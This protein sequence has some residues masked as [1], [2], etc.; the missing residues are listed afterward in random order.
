MQRSMLIFE[1]SIN[2][3]ST[4]RVYIYQLNRFL[5]F[6]DIKDYDELANTEQSKIQIMMEDYVMYLKK[7]VSPN[8][9]NGPISAIRAF[10]DCNDIELRW[11]KI[12][13]LTPAKVKKSG[14]EAW[15]TE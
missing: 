14:V 12:K 11:S 4:K 8:T 6:F 7:K 9:I 3:E 13:R 2:S 15:L 5:K 10:L 1:N